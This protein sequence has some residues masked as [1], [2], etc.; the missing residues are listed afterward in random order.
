[1]GY[2]HTE[3]CILR[4]FKIVRYVLWFPSTLGSGPL[5]T[6]LCRTRTILLRRDTSKDRKETEK[7]STRTTSTCHGE[8]RRWIG[9][10]HSEEMASKSKCEMILSSGSNY[11]VTQSPVTYFEKSAN[12]VRPRTLHGERR[13][14]TIDHRPSTIDHR[15][16]EAT[17]NSI[18]HNDVVVVCKVAAG[19]LTFVTSQLY[20]PEA[21][22]HW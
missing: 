15:P 22:L 20:Y 13:P 11:F 5:V 3:Y 10:G 14:S 17:S 12:A 21:K 1:M 9:H 4:I 19:S 8:D 2:N 16:C 7:E 18:D 6:R